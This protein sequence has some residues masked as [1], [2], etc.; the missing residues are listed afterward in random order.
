MGQSLTNIWLFS[1]L[2][3]VLKSLYLEK[4]TIIK[5]YHKGIIK[6]SKKRNWQGH[7]LMWSFSDIMTEIAK[8]M[9]AWDS[10]DYIM[11]PFA[12]VE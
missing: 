6:K 2:Y 4:D 7:T 10:K 1:V 3:W 5:S 9:I 11:S 8:C 12:T